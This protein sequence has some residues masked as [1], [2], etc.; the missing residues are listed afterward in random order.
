MG[1]LVNPHGL[2]PYVMQRAD[3]TSKRYSAIVNPPDNVELW[4]KYEEIYRDVDNPNRKDEA[5]DFYFMNQEEMDKGT[6]VLW[7]D[8]MPYYKLIQEKVNVGT[9]AFNSEYLNLPYSSDVL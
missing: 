2:L 3:F 8:R 7:Q 1:T 9:R 6:K 4:E 5:E